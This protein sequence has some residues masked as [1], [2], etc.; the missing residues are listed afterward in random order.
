MSRLFDDGS[1][2][3]A[4]A[5][6]S[7]PAELYKFL[8]SLCSETKC[9]WDCACGSGQ[10][11]TDLTRFFG[12]VR[13]TD[14]SL[15]QIENAFKHPKVRYTVC[16]SES[17]PF[18]ENTFDMVCVA[19]A[20]HWLDFDRFWPEVKRVLKPGGVFAAWGYSWMS[21]NAAIDLVLREAFLDV[22]A[23][24]WAEQNKLLWNHYQAVALPFRTI[25]TP[26]FEMK[27]RWDLEQL[28]AYLHTWSATKR[29]VEAT[30]EDF[31][32]E[33]YDQAFSVW[34]NP[35]ERKDVALDFCCVVGRNEA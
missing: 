13:A 7:Y 16:P 23:P 3:Y 6:P 17:T 10:A 19:Q 35:R 1:S 5:R 18:A 8:G 25:Q 27:M 12:D 15:N 30:G 4:S 31:F 29:C 14:V 20:L 34:G 9:V 26:D 24:Y 32:N 22:I 11:A 2:F 33:A 28:F 21:V